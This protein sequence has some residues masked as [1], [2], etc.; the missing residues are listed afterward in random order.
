MVTARYEKELFRKVA[1][2][3][4]KKKLDKMLKRQKKFLID[5]VANPVR[6]LEKQRLNTIQEA[7]RREDFKNYLESK[8]HNQ[9]FMEQQSARTE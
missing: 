2:A 9:K 1:E 8:Y 3:E 7:R 5:S 4:E 6:E